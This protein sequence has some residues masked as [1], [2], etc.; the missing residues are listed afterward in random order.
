MAIFEL[1][2]FHR[3]CFAS[4]PFAAFKWLA[5][6]L[7]LLSTQPL[8]SFSVVSSGVVSPL[9]G[10][11]LIGTPSGV[12]VDFNGNTYVADTTN[13]QILKI[14]RDGATASPLAIS[15]LSPALSSPGGLAIDSSGNLYIADTGN[16]RIV[17]VSPSGA[18]SVISTSSITLN[19]P[20]GVAVD[21]SGNLFIS[22]TGNSQVVKVASGG[23]AS[24]FT[25]TGLSTALSNQRGIAADP[26]G[27]LYVADTGNS[28]VVKVSSAGAAG[29]PLTTAAGTALSGPSG[30]AIGNNGVLYVADTNTESGH[31][32][33]GRI[34]IVNSQGTPSELLTGFPVFNSP[35]AVAVDS[36]GKIYVVDNGGTANTGRVQSFQSFT[37]DPSDTFTTSVG[38]GHVPLSSGTPAGIPLPF[39]VGLDTTLTSVSIYTAGTQNLDFTIA[40]D[41]TCAPG[42][43]STP[44]IV[45]VTFSPTAAGLRTGALVL[46]YE[47]GSLTV[48]LFGIADA[49][50]SALSPGVA[51]VLNI[52][53]AAL[54]SPFQSAV[55]AAGNIYIANYGNNTI[56][57]IPSAGGS[58]TT[59]STGS[60]TLSRPTGVALDAAGNLFIADYGNSRIIKVPANGAPSLF[61]LTGLSQS[62]ALPTAL[63][64]DAAGNLFITDYGLGRM[65]EVNP[66]GQATVLATGS[67]TF[68]PTTITGTAVDALGN[69]YIAD[70][71]NNRIIKVDPLGKTVTLSLSSIGALSSPQGVAVDPSGNLYIIDSSN[72]RIIRVTTSGAVSVMA[73]SGVIIGS[74]VFGATADANGNLLVADWSNNRLVKINVGQ[75]ILAYANTNVGGTSSDSPKTASVTDLGDQP[76]AFSAAPAFTTNFSQ[77]G[78]DTNPCTSSTTLTPGTS[79]DVSIAFSPQSAGSL[80]ANITVTTNTL[81]VANSTQQIAVSGTG[82][83][84]TTATTIAI[85]PSSA[86][87][88]Q[89]VTIAATVTDSA[90]GQTSTIPTGSVSFIDVVGS[91]VTQVN[92]GVTLN[93][94]GTAT[95]TGVVL[96]GLGTHT[97]TASYPGANNTF[98]ASNNSTTLALTQSSVIVTGPATQ[99]VSVA[100]SQ[101]GSVPVTVTGSYTG[102]SVPSGTVSYSIVDAS[103]ATVSSGVAPLTTASAG[104]TASV[105]VPGSLAPGTYTIIIT[106]LGD[107][108]Y[109]ASSAISVTLH[110]GQNAATTSLGSSANPSIVTTAVTFT[111]TTSSS[112]GTPTGTVSFFDGTTLL[113]TAT[114]SPTGQAS[115]TT[116]ALTAGSHSITAAYSGDA[117]FSA[118]TSSALAQLVQDFALSTPTS[119][120]T[121]APA[122]TV[123][124]GGTAIYS[125]SIGPSLGTVFPLPI[126]LSVSGLPPGA[127]ATLSPQTLPAGSS[128]TAV[129]LSIQLPTQTAELHR[130]LRWVT[131]T[132]ALLFLPFAGKMRRK[133]KALE[134]YALAILLVAGAGA[135]AGLMGCGAKDTGFFGQAE[136]TYTVLITATSGS[137]SHSTSVTLTVQ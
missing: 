98:L 31:P 26:L 126:T 64:F 47:S 127:T 44:C 43:T 109:H 111:T 58:G 108:N 67:V 77:N 107:T 69:V 70:R 117:S 123:T 100:S 32:T 18:A 33:P 39:A 51:T 63:A 90:S 42:I 118:D 124:P 4:P 61:Q 49:P 86:V 68:A 48:P 19:A 80:S 112:S 17:E 130:S 106:Y 45:D 6:L 60:Y 131:P 88:G 132:L 94:S 41:S 34:V 136:Q 103:H 101:T 20:Q 119:G 11:S 96:Q 9:A 25:I 2:S 75:S 135:M 13:S 114:L 97:I 82:L 10:N 12:V 79:C 36:M 57:K 3:R 133:A 74:F 28:R 29:T 52:G 38:F 59:V 87:Y 104:A 89:A 54:S 15:G 7:I 56:V 92:S 105:P 76:L 71:A 40:N 113:G 8:W 91:T 83:G 115:Y 102:L 122:A 37:I 14:I 73:S 53:S 137:L 62:I 93:A 85:T 120:T 46:T 35:S 110:V 23:T 81:N 65:V 95:L 1:S 78:A 128:L 27:N 5:C 129:T 84:Q 22:D 55:D 116:A 66:F 30:V 125:L 99:P 72:R 16:S 24:V 134:Q 50:V 121:N 21:P